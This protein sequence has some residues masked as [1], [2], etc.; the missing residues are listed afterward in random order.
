[1]PRYFFVLQHPDGTLD[2]AEGAILP[3]DSA[4]VEYAQ[5]IVRELKNGG[6]H[7]GPGLTLI[8][9]DDAQRIVCSVPF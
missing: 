8:V 3:T 5:R 4:A 6:D 7:D 9:K 2:D 1:M